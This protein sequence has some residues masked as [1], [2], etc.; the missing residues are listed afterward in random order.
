MP[1]WDTGK[2]Q[3][4][5]RGI[6]PYRVNQ[7][8]FLKN[9]VVV[10]C[11]A[12]INFVRASK[13]LT[14]DRTIDRVAQ[15]LKALATKSHGL[16]WSTRMHMMEGENLLWQVFSDCLDIRCKP[17][18]LPPTENENIKLLKKRFFKIPNSVKCVGSTLRRLRP[19]DYFKLKTSLDYMAGVDQPA[20]TDIIRKSQ[21]WSKWSGL[22]R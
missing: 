8:S 22:L 20:L 21:A 4:K 18:E 11:F 19:E 16:G 14:Y 10:K 15:W 6:C 12:Y 17:Q 9:Q 1:V 13:T 2:C 3:Y 7:Q 5:I